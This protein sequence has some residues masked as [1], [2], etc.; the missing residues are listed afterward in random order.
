MTDKYQDRD[1]ALFF[2]EEKGGKTRSRS[3]VIKERLRR[4]VKKI[5]T[6][7]FGLLRGVCCP[8]CVAADYEE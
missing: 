3:I 7:P 8:C 2:Y 6:F 5:K 1:R 4:F